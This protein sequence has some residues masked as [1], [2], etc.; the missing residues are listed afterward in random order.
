[1]DYIRHITYFNLKIQN[2]SQHF[3]IILTN[4]KTNLL[5]NIMHLL[6]RHLIAAFQLH[7]V[8]QHRKKTMFLQNIYFY[9]LF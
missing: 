5:H 8:L 2:I 4:L 3:K 6:I 9:D 1:M 7:M